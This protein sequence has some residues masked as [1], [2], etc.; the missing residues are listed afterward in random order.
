M[1][2]VG[3]FVDDGVLQ[4]LSREADEVP[5]EVQ[6][7]VTAAGG[8]DVLLLFDADPL[9][10]EPERGAVLPGDLAGIVTDT[11]LHPA[12]QALPDNGLFVFPG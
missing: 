12:C 3:E 1:L 8:P 6:D 2:E 10:G 9:E 4:G 5:V 11:T 7:A